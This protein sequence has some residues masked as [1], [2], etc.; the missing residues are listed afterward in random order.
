MVFFKQYQIQFKSMASYYND[1]MGNS[2]SMRLIMNSAIDLNRVKL[3][4]LGFGKMLFFT[5][6]FSIEPL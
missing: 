5:W 2:A 3:T 1:Y 6:F 4:D